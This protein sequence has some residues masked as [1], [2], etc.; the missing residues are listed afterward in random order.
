MRIPCTLLL[1]F[2]SLRLRARFPQHHFGDTVRALA[3]VGHTT[4]AGVLSEAK[5]E[6]DTEFHRGFR[7][8]AIF[9][10]RD[11]YLTILSSF[12]SRCP[13][14]ATG[15]TQVRRAVSDLRQPEVRPQ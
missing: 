15:H 8:P 10:W 3:R 1:M 12:N 6:H 11:R 7:N 13:R 5:P 4:N 9:S 2:A 14:P